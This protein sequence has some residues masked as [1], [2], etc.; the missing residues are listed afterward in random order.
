MTE[1]EQRSIYKNTILETEIKSYNDKLSNL[2]KEVSG[3]KERLKRLENLEKKVKNG[4]NTFQ[5]KMKEK[6]TKISSVTSLKRKMKIAK[7]YIEDMETY[8]GKDS[9]KYKVAYGAYEVIL[10]TVKNEINTINTKISN[11][12][13][14]VESL[15]NSLEKAKEEYKKNKEEKHGE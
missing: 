7:I 15:N 6:R 13:T 3:L 12:E 11:K 9:K 8:I 10:E 1:E 4:F 2:K 14:Q 5:S